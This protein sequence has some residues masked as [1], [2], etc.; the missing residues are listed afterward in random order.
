MT[1]AGVPEKHFNGVCV[2][3]ETMAPDGGAIADWVH[4][5]E[6]EKEIQPAAHGILTNGRLDSS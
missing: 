6:V 4:A 2:L 5:P 3:V 1:A